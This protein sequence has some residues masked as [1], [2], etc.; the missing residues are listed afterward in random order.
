MSKTHTQTCMLHVPGVDNV[1]VAP[2]HM[3]AQLVQRY[4]HK[5]TNHLED[6]PMQ[7]FMMHHI[8]SL[9]WYRTPWINGKSTMSHHHIPSP[10]PRHP[11]QPLF[12]NILK[13]SDFGV[14]TSTQSKY[15][16]IGGQASDCVTATETARMSDSRR[17]AFRRMFFTDRACY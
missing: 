16:P 5:P 10:Q 2:P 1:R 6:S 9:C 8:P 13:Q 3:S 7:S 17:F 11:Q 15:I 12:E 14:Q 4:M